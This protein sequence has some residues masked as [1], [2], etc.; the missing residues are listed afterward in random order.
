MR[1]RITKR[2]SAAIAAAVLIGVAA[3]T[4]PAYAGT[5]IGWTEVNL[6]WPSRPEVGFNG[7]G[8]FESNGDLVTV[9]DGDADGFGVSAWLVD[10]EGYSLAPSVHVGG[11]GK[12]VTRTRNLREGTA[13]KLLVCLTKGSHGEPCKTSRLGAA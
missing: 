6:P 3:S 13:V 2:V 5:D 7:A 11:K 4:T 12:C 1:I 9:C 8:E 10:S